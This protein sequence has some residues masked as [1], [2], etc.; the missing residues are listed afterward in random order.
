MRRRTAPPRSHIGVHPLAPRHVGRHCTTAC[1][2]LHAWLALASASRASPEMVP[3]PGSHTGHA[4]RTCARNVAPLLVAPAPTYPHTPYPWHIRCEYLEMKHCP[5]VCP[6][7]Y[8][9]S[10]QCS[11]RARSTER[12]HMPL[13]PPRWASPPLVFDTTQMT[14][15]LP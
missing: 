10:L 3:Q 12:R 15:P 11:S 5:T 8:K 2:G 13:T 7:A 6:L 1:Q 4:T 14:Q 9:R